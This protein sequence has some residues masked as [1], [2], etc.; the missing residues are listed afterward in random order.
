MSQAAERGT[1]PDATDVVVVGAGFAGLY[2]LHRLRN[3]GLSAIAFEAG[4]DVGGTWYW[5]RYPGARC[6]VES[7][8]YSYGFS[9]EIQQEWHWPEL[10]SAQPDILRYARFVADKLDLRR[11]IRF[12]TRVT[13]AHFNEATRR[14]TVRTDQGDEVSAR[15]CVMATG[16]LSTTQLPDFPGLDGFR[17]ATYHTGHWPHEGVD[18][19]GKRVGQIGTGSTGIQAVPVIAAQAKHLTVFQRTANYSIP[20]RN[21]PLTPAFKQY[22]KT[23][24]DEIRAVMHSTPNGHPFTIN[25]RKVFDVDDAE[26]QRIF[27]DGWEKGGLQFRA[28]FGDVLIDEKANAEAAEFIKRKIR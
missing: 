2:M 18:F 20:A 17:G 4:E 5:N 14:W 3:Q 16:C 24:A 13:A 6:D 11:D 21:V 27:E 7:V 8:Q 9:N 26:R 12:S 10:Y 25:P 19:T 28:A 23:H 22:V 15:Y 1:V